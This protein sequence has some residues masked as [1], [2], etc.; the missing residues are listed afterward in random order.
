MSEVRQL[1][2]RVYTGT[3]KWFD[4]GKG[5]GFVVAPGVSRDILLH[6]NVLRNFG[7]NSVADHSKITIRVVE[8]DRGI[9]AQEVMQI[10]P[11]EIGAGEGA[12]ALPFDEGLEG[13]ELEPARVKWFDGSKGFGF[14]NVFGLGEDVFVHIE[15]LRRSSL[16]DLQP[17]E[18][19]AVRVAEGARGKLATQ[20]SVW[21][22][23]VAREP[24][25]EDGD[26]DGC[27]AA[28]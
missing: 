12:R 3:V 17:G 15:V 19:I 25:A 7:Q 27:E 6:A 21:E 1:H 23:A 20:V 8:T 4:S 18:A 10:E 2:D 24:A 13:G 28:E 9:Q 26:W 22:S 5:Y 11:P 14:V 16:A